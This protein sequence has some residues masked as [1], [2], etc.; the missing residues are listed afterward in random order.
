MCFS[1]LIH[2]LA[3]QT[4][5]P[6]AMKTQ[7]YLFLCILLISC[8]ET[9]D[10]PITASRSK[11]AME[12]FTHTQTIEEQAYLNSI[13]HPD[14]ISQNLQ[15]LV[16][17]DEF[18]LRMFKA[19]AEELFDTVFSIEEIPVFSELSTITRIY[20]NGSS[21][22]EINDLTP[23]G[24]NPTSNFYETP[25][26]IEDKIVKTVIEGGRMITYNSGGRV[27]VN[28]PYDQENFTQF[29]DT[30]KFYL[31]KVQEDSERQYV[32]SLNYLMNYTQ[33]NGGSLKYQILESGEVEL[34]QEF[35][36]E[37]KVN[38]LI[39]N[40][41]VF[42][43]TTLDPTMSRTMR[44]EIRNGEQL[45]QK[46]TYHYSDKEELRNSIYKKNGY[47]ENPQKIETQTLIFN[48]WG[49]PV[50]RKVSETYL[51]NQ[52]FFYF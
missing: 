31:K 43:K 18:S 21:D 51:R 49:K 17:D 44:S 37:E 42:V 26:D 30:L 11:I 52:S 16:V 47:G 35:S 2:S 8:Q 27:L 25:Q 39:Q 3:H 40:T 34:Q 41:R 9:I 23:E 48:M 12:I 4:F 46:K 50:I 28:E 33:N 45:I 19:P 24:I 20:E 22:V 10:V 13:K 36:M 1:N 14:F 7:H 6:F 38:D 29:L 15:N 5:I 32:R